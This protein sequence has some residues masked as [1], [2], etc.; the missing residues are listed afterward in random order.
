MTFRFGAVMSHPT[1]HHAP[2]FREM[3][4][5]PG[6][7]VKVFYCS[8]WGVQPTRD[9]GFGQTFAWDVPLLDGYEYEFLPRDGKPRDHSFFQID[10][11]R[12]GERLQQ[13]APHAFWL[14]GYGHRSSWRA[15][16]W[17]RRRAATVY[18]GDSELLHH[19]S[20]AVRALKELVLRYYFR[21]C[22]AFITIGDNNE[23]YYRHYG[24]SAEKLFRGAYPVDIARFQARLADPARPGRAELRRRYGIPENAIVVLFLGKMMLIKR[25]CDLLTAMSLLRG[26]NTGLHAL[27]VGDG[28]LRPALEQQTRE[29]GLTDCVHFTGFVNQHDLPPL[30]DCA[31]ILAVPSVQDAHPL[32]VTEALVAGIV[33]AASDRVGCVGPTDT[34]RPGVNGLVFPCGDARA[35]ADALA[36]LAGD[37]PLRRRM[38]EASRRLAATQDLGVAI[39]AVLEAILALRP[40]WRAA[41]ADVPDAIFDD[42]RAYAS[43]LP[44]AHADISVEPQLNTI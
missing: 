42:L 32:A 21:R 36:R 14:H 23:A 27:L 40:T 19:R 38:S 34:V 2:M 10:N 25:A 12:I 18:F 4:R 39:R 16:R 31:D 44:S 33:V 9:P 1:Q 15:L 6:L 5:T 13:F 26:T 20:W 43:T 8:D 22:Q 37:E 35:L 41:W 11:P 24:V 30:I 28:E 17:A 7:H 3:S 29:L